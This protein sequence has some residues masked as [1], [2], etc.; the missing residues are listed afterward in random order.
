MSIYIR[1]SQG[2]QG[3]PASQAKPPNGRG[4]REA[5]KVPTKMIPN[6]FFWFDE[7][8]PRSTNINNYSSQLYVVREE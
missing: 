4:E 6:F 7:F 1:T 5:I 3:Y 8:D 2:Q